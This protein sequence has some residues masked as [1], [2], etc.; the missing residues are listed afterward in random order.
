[1]STPTKLARLHRRI[2]DLSRLVRWSCHR[3]SIC[4]R[5]IMAIAAP[6]VKVYWVISNNVRLPDKRSR[7]KVQE[8]VFIALSVRGRE[9]CRL[10]VGRLRWIDRSNG[11]RES[12]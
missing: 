11:M 2:P 7:A 1:M 12:D 9:G 3:N 8:A 4:D 5:M 10:R 6:R